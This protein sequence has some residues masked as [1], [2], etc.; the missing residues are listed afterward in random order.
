MPGLYDAAAR[1]QG[2]RVGVALGLAVGL[3]VAL[4]LPEGLGDGETPGS[5]RGLEGAGHDP[6][7]GRPYEHRRLAAR[8]LDDGHAVQVEVAG[9][10]RL[11]DELALVGAVGLGEGEDALVARVP[12]PQAALAARRRSRPGAGSRGPAGRRPGREAS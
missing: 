11:D 10:A 1:T 9:A 5:G 6:V 3:G 12:D 8:A 2:R 7:R 4:P